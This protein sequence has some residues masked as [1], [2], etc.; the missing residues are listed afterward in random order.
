MSPPSQIFPML[1]RAPSLLRRC[2]LLSVALLALTPGHAATPSSNSGAL[3][4]G[5]TI[6]VA[7]NVSGSTLSFGGGIDPLQTTGPV[8]ASTSLA[9]TCTRTTPYSVAL[10]A[11]ANAGGATAF[12]NRTMKSGNHLLPYQLYLDAGR[13]QVWGNGSNSGVHSGTGTGSTQSLTV[14]GRLPSLAGVVPGDYSDT[15]TVTITY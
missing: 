12:G 10:S 14:Y 6:V 3:E 9:V 13:T 2:S 1:F 4:V 11:G 8:D 7:C 15:V 5:A